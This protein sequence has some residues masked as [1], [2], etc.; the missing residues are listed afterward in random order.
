MTDYLIPLVFLVAVVIQAWPGLFGR[1]IK[2]EELQQHY[3][4]SLLTRR[5]KL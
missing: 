1:R 2:S 4:D 5:Y 3:I